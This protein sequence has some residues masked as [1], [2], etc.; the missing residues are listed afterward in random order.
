MSTIISTSKPFFA[1]QWPAPSNIK[2]CSTLRYPGQCMGNYAEFNLALHV[3]DEAKNV[4][5]NRDDLIVSANLP[6]PPKW[7]NQ[8]HSNQCILA[9]NVQSDDAINIIPPSLDASHTRQNNVVCVVMT[10]DCLP[11]LVTNKSGTEIAAIHAGWRGLADDVVENTLSAL[12][13]SP[14]SLMIWIGPSISKSYYEVGED[15]YNAFAKYHTKE[16]CDA[17]FSPYHPIMDTY[18]SNQDIPPKKW[19]VDMP[20]LAEQRLIRLGVNK[21][22]IYLSRECTYAQSDRY[23]SYRRDGITGRMAS[24]IWME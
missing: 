17:A 6:A 15:V 20:L 4:Q 23:F 22:D 5:A 24:L 13:S 21:Q 12:Q 7:L 11:I 14:D 18:K 8:I 16:E 9:E 3:G 10:A 2:A 19:L 1:P